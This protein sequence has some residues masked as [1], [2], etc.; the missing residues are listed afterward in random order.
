MA[1]RKS[2]PSGSSGTSEVEALKAELKSLK[3]EIKKLKS[4][5]YACCSDCGKVD[6]RV[7]AIYAA[8]AKSPNFFLSK[9][10][11]GD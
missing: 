10:L 1:T 2:S 3:T 5:L 6:S 9:E 11:L 4:E 8:L 7:D